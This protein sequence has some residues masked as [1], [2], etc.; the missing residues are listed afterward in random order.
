MFGPA[1]HVFVAVLKT[2]VCADPE[3]HGVPMLG[4]APMKNTVP[5]G[6]STPGPISYDALLPR[7]L[8]L[9]ASDTGVFPAPLQT[10]VVGL[11]RSES[12]LFAGVASI[13]KSE[14]S[15]SNVQR[16]RR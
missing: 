1:D 14:L 7:A 4:F 3:Q 6:R 9:S 15:G 13:V 2:A 8:S 12:R 16:T 11:N 5:F 10:P